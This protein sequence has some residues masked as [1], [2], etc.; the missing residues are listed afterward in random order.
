MNAPPEIRI[1]EWRGW[2]LHEC[3][4][5]AST[6]DHARHLGPWNAIRADAQTAGRGR[7]GRKWESGPGGL[8][9]SAVLPL[10]PPDRHWQA[11]PLVA[12]LAVVSMLR[13]FG[14]REARLRWPN[15][16]MIGPCKICGIL[17]ERFANDRVVVGL[18][19][20]IANRP[21][22][23][24]PVLASIATSLAEEL[25]A[26][27]PAADICEELLIALRALHGRV[28]EDG[29]ASLVDEINHHW[30]GTH[31]VEIR[32]SG[33]MIRGRF[34]GIDSRGDLLVAT[35]GRT[36]TFSAPHVNLLREISP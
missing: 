34:L 18:G 14:L 29:F 32:L 16:V 27:P 31:D 11:F 6:N 21:A 7:H 17:M 12:G 30:G 5:I 3:A 24:D 9:I 19:L 20:N 26:P 22:T 25:P 4:S 23:A 2:T 35:E 15:D 13:G 10:A 1:R 8:W 28:A 33:E 36:L